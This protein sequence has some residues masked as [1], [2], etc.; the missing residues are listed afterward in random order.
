MEEQLDIVI[1]GGGPAGLSAAINSITRGCS[2][3]V[4]DS[5]STKLTRAERI[6]NYLGIPSVTGNEMMNRFVRHARRLGV[7]I[8][9]GMVTSVLP[10][11][12]QFL[13][14]V[15]NHVLYAKAL[16]M[17]I[18]AMRTNPIEG[19][20]K[21]LGR[22]VS[23]CTTCDGMLYRG[24]KVVVYGMTADA[25][26]EANYLSDI[27][28]KVVYVYTGQQPE[29]LMPNIECFQGELSFIRGGDTVRSVGFSGEVPLSMET[30]GVFLLR[31]AIAPHTLVS[32][33]QT[34]NGFISVGGD[35]KTNIPGIF[36]CGDCTGPPLQISKAAA[37]GLFAGQAAARY[38]DGLRWGK[39]KG[40]D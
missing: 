4:L 11:E 13:I 33:I 37:E 21:Y 27:G 10:M 29:G 18:G 30:D 35:R 36:A 32:G 12:D 40:K 2:V 17:A 22:G 7:L 28:V 3:L 31:D 39:G 9:K 15:G 8:Q 23:Y 1:I 38:I 25:P 16:V 20:E 5:G 34:E 24:K 6:E 19:E 14:S 26:D